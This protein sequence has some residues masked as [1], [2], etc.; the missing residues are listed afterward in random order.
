MQATLHNHHTPISM[1]GRHIFNLQFSGDI[2][3]VGDSNGALQ[4][5]I[6]LLLYRVGAY[7]ME[8]ATIKSKIMTSSINNISTDISMNV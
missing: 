3:L 1:S 8:V 4:D 7:G 2:D 5:L 6:N